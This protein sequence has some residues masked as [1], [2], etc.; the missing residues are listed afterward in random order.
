MEEACKQSV[1][2]IVMVDPEDPEYDAKL[3]TRQMVAR[4][5]NDFCATLIKSIWMHTESGKLEE[6]QQKV[7]EALQ[8]E[9]VV[10]GGS[11]VLG[12]ARIKP[13][14]EQLAEGQ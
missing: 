13:R 10:D 5:V 8:E 3:R 2:R 14:A 11:T 1:D 4:V 7:L 6:Q 12:S 9:V